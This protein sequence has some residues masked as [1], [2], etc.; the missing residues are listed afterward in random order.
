MPATEMKSDVLFRNEVLALVRASSPTLLRWIKRKG[1]PAPLKG[2]PGGK[3]VWSRRA[4]QKWLSRFTITE[5]PVEQEIVGTDQD[6]VQVEDYVEERVIVPE[7]V[8][9]PLDEPIPE[10]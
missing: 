2:W 7:R 9:V 6:M 4:V 3:R 10:L 5:I 1:F 8:V